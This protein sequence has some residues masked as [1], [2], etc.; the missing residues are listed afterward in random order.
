[1]I[2]VIRL[3]IGLSTALFLTTCVSFNNFS[4][5]GDLSEM[6]K[7][8]V[9]DRD[10]WVFRLNLDD[11][12]RNLVFALNKELW[13]SYD[14]QIGGLYRAWVGGINFNGIIFNNAHGVQPNSL[15]IPYI[16]DNLEE[17]PWAISK[18]GSSKKVTA[19]YNGYVLKDDHVVIK[20]KIPISGNEYVLVEERPEYITNNEG[21]PGLHREF[22]V[23]DLPDG[24]EISH[25]IKIQHLISPENLHTNSKVVI[26][27]IK[28]NSFEWGSSFDLEGKIFLKSKGKTTLQTF[29]P[30]QLYR[31]EESESNSAILASSLVN[32]NELSGKDLIGQLGCVACH[33]IDKGVLGPAYNDVA[34]KYDNSQ[35]SINYLVNQIK[36]G[37]KGVWGE[38]LMPPHPH[39]NDDDA[40]KIVEFI[41]SL[42]QFAEGEYLPGVAVDFYEIGTKLMSQPTLLPGQDPNLSQVFPDILFQSGNPDIGWEDQVTDDFLHFERNFVMKVSAYLNIEEE[43]DY[44]FRF[45]ADKGGSFKIDGEEIAFV[46][47]IGYTPWQG[48][49]L[50]RFDKFA[51]YIEK[52]PELG[53]ITGAKYLTKGFHKIDIDYH[54]NILT[55][56]LILQWREKGKNKFEFVPESVLFHDPRDI[57]PTSSGLK[58][59]YQIEAPGHGGSLVSVHPSFDLLPARPDSFEPR[60]GGMDFLSNG[61]L[62]IATWD[63]EVF[64]VK[65]VSSG[66]PSSMSVQKIADG[67]CEPLGLAVANDDIYVMQRWE[68]TKLVDQDG[69]G[70]TDYYH[71]FSDGWSTT[72]DFHAWGFGLTYKDG[73]FY[74]NTGAAL[75]PY[76]KKQAPDAG[77]TLK[78]SINDGLFEAIA[79]G[80]KAPNGIGLGY[81]GDIFTTDN[82]GGYVPTSK[83][84]HLDIDNS[85]AYP[86]FGNA[87]VLGKKA[88]GLKIKPPV[89]WIPQDEIGNSPSQPGI[90]NVGPYQNQMIMGD[91]RHGGIKRIFIEKVNGQLQ[92]AVFRFTQGL[93]AGINR[94]VWGP[95]SSLYVGGVGGTN[96]FTWEGKRFGL[97]K[98]SYNGNI[99]FEMLSVKAKQNGM[100]IEFTEPLR[101]GD[102]LSTEDYLVQQWWYDIHTEGGIKQDINNLIVNSVSISADRKKVFLEINSLKQD[103]VIYIKTRNPILSI[104][105]KQLWSSEAWYTM[106]S[107]P[108]ESAEISPT[109]FVRKDN[110]L[111]KEVLNDGWSLLFD[112]QTTSG[113]KGSDGKEEPESW[114]TENGMLTNRLQGQIILTE[115]VFDN[116]ELEF[117]WKIERGGDS[118][119]FFHVPDS[120]TSGSISTIGPEMQIIDDQS[121][122]AEISN[123]HITGSFYDV[124]P[125]KYRISR[126]AG[127]FN[128]SRIVVLKDHIEHWLNGLLVLEYQIGGEAWSQNIQNSLFGGY[129]NFGRSERGHIAIMNQ[130]G[131][132]WLKNI[133]VRNL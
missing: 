109:N 87:Y 96:D 51:K 13:L 11:R 14:P 80:Y 107:I 122:A 21:Q 19:E 35:E 74:T 28:E 12:P 68:L 3:V 33:Y 130:Q 129:S 98:L 23:I 86:F 54:Q 60:V 39:I 119:L 79:H 29:F 49:D 59:I 58:E 47:R 132:I 66:D 117:Y 10:P 9:R 63:G 32:E 44:E 101:I 110:S 120:I 30:K 26:S 7:E 38:R 57:K 67:L 15:G 103:H 22:Q 1:M 61:D 56:A 92:G 46:H 73:Y 40:L 112:G 124:L 90:L 106:N 83:L 91:A 78:I 20:Y 81:G 48:G 113:W 105:N 126:P 53:K 77:K 100:E 5:D 118:G 84:M 111:S 50:S 2:H 121:N 70:V 31:K 95:D 36:A 65:N 34:K 115:S 16:L 62:A 131:R 133:R 94:F 102:G 97:E 24:Y 89:V 85:N 18:N 82:E 37:G 127:Q 41:L 125:P 64:I 71:S 75:G 72:P 128:H 104:S 43:G 93:E 6:P 17:T 69:D 99:T 116:F 88:K 8:I 4:F 27:K 45:I 76:N 42:D 108:D 123:T 25:S 55:M 52:E 114:E